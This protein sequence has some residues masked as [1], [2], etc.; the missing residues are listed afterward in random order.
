[1]LVDQSPEGLEVLRGSSAY[2][3]DRNWKVQAKNGAD[4]Y[5]V[6]ATHWN[7]AATTSWCSTGES[8][9]TAKALHAGGWGTFGG[10]YWPHHSR[11]GSDRRRPGSPPARIR[12][13][14]ARSPQRPAPG[15][16]PAAVPQR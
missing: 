16:G 10:G 15:Q 1:M 6:S 14:A 3:Y 9:N 2:T 8:E 13:I 4:G 11:C 7:Y 5:H 12:T